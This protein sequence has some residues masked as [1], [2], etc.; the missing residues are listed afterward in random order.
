M[1]LKLASITS[2][3]LGTM[4]FSCCIRDAFS[5]L[6]IR[7]PNMSMKFCVNELAVC[8]SVEVSIMSPFSFCA[9]PSENMTRILIEKE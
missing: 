3:G 8:S 2:T 6:G 7:T 9:F 5:V 4:L 1:L